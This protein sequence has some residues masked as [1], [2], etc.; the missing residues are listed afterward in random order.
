ME[1][2]KKTENMIF[3]HSYASRLDSPPL[4][5]GKLVSFYKN[6]TNNI[7]DK[8][9]AIKLFFHLKYISCLLAR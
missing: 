9:K 8:N 3:S 5:Y 1:M 4:N 2:Q 6:Y 7:T